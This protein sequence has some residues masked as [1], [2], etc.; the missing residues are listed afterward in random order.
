[1]PAQNSNLYK[2]FSEGELACKGSGV[3]KLD[4]RFEK[5]LLEYRRKIMIP[6]Y[7]NSCCRT[8]AHNKAIGGASGSYHL[9][10]HNDGREGTMAIDLAVTDPVKRR[11]MIELAL[12]LGWSV[13]V[14]KTF[15]HID[16]R[17][18]LL[19]AQIVFYGS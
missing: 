1:M 19:K 17:K 5:A 18:D 8:P 15:I 13:G 16:R 12:K 4:P 14:Y 9:T 10:E 3:L 7:V 2:Y 11:L 6:L